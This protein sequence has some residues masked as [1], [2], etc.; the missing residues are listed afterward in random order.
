M[1]SV[2]QTIINKIKRNI[3]TTD[4]DAV[5]A[6]KIGDSFEDIKNDTGFYFEFVD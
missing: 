4:T 2:T 3:T 5:I 1:D 6:A